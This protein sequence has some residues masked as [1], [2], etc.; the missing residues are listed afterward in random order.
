M[1]TVM[2]DTLHLALLENFADAGFVGIRIPEVEALHKPRPVMQKIE[3]LLKGR[4]IEKADEEEGSGRYAVTDRGQRV[5]GQAES[6]KLKP[7][8]PE[9]D[10]EYPAAKQPGKSKSSET[11]KKPDPDGQEAKTAPKP[12]SGEQGKTPESLKKPKS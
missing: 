12:G 4:L 2:F 11:K 5:L 1:D 9:G 7:K 6:G 3:E 8:K 10:D